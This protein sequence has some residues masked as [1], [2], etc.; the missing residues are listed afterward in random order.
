MV[1]RSEESS[2]KIPW[3]NMPNNFLGCF[4]P[5][6]AIVW[7]M[8]WIVCCINFFLPAGVDALFGNKRKKQREAE[9]L[10]KKLAAEAAA[11]QHKI[12]VAI[13]CFTVILVGIL[14]IIL[15]SGM[16]VIGKG[17]KR[18]NRPDAKGT[19]D[20]VVVGCG[21]PKKSMVS[22]SIESASVLF[23]LDWC[24]CLIFYLSLKLYL[25]G[26]RVGTI[27]FSFLKCP[28]STS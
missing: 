21:L 4:M 23:N 2:T 22:L 27:P 3:Q 5:Q 26:S 14:S 8:I 24:L 1:G 25:N 18:G 15:F 28:M 20:V 11:R 17:K 12:Y 19:V 9:L 6:S 16:L 10:A 13:A 7:S